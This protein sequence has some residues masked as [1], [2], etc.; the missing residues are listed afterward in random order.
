MQ[1]VLALDTSTDACSV[2]LD[3][4]GR[5]HFRHHVEA[6]AHNRLLL[7]MIEEVLAEAGLAPADLDALAFG[8]GPG[9]FTG[10]RIAAAVTQGLAWAHELP[11]LGVSS[12]EILAAEALLRVADAGGVITLLDARMGECYWNAFDNG[13]GGLQA[14]GE[15]GLAAPAALGPEIQARC[16]AGPGRWLLVGAELLPESSWP[17]WEG[18]E[19]VV[20]EALIPDARTLLTLARPRLEAG[21]GLTAREAV[22]AYLRDASRWRRLD[23]PPPDRRM[24][25]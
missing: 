19:V 16:A 13:S 21:Q 24:G 10:L 17:Q 18:C 12:L 14:L 8:R 7:P 9:S 3:H 20:M 4:G 6:R 25:A 22:P 11:V 15:D 1:A 2:A 5:V 23:D